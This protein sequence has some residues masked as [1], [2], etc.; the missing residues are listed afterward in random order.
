MKKVES[1]FVRLQN[2]ILGTPIDPLSS[3]FNVSFQNL[4]PINLDF[5]GLHRI[6][7]IKSAINIKQVH[8]R[9]KRKVRIINREVAD[10]DVFF[11]KELILNVFDIQ[12]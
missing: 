6:K 10:H 1:A 9:I 12:I 5:K 7:I 8:F 11:V 3:C 2:Y 4:I